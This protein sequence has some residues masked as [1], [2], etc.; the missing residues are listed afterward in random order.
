MVVFLGLKIVMVKSIESQ[1]RLIDRRLPEVGRQ[2]SDI[3]PTPN[4]TCASL[5][6]KTKTTK[7]TAYIS[8][9][10]PEA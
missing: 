10:L 8:L 5:S 9:R 3:L 6:F 1:S 7:L 4:F 2:K